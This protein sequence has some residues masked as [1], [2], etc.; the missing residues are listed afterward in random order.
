MNGHV[1]DRL[2]AYLDGELGADEREV[3]EAHLEGCRACERHLDELRSVD[4]AARELTVEAPPGY[5]E[6]FPARVRSRLPA[7]RPRRVSAWLWAAAAVFALG[8]LAPLLVHRFEEP[9]SE[10]ARREP[11]APGAAAGGLGGPESP[12][13]SRASANS[14]RAGGLGGPESPPGSRASATSLGAG[15]LGGPESP[16][17][18]MASANSLRASEDKPADKVLAA[19]PKTDLSVRLAPPPPAPE[20]AEAGGRLKQRDEGPSAPLPYQ[21]QKRA[22]GPYAQNQAAASTA[23]AAPG[24]AAPAAQSATVPPPAA[25]REEVTADAAEVKEPRSDDKRE[26]DQ[27]PRE[28]ERAPETL[29]GFSEMSKDAARYRQLIARRAAAPAEARQLHDQWRAFA[30]AFP[31]GAHADEARVRAIE[32]MALAFHL[33]GDPRDRDRAQGEGEAYLARTDA[34]QAARVRAVLGSLE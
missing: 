28:V 7:A 26:Q 31:T 30:E 18:S 19:Q 25:V 21:V 5:F 9:V 24:Q 10:S 32:A 27:L 1:E 2:S 16:P 11:A 8:A 3:V 15:G 17:S 12:P 34:G 14:L 29:A 6:S 20:R 23:G 22:G 4:A 33:G 13:G